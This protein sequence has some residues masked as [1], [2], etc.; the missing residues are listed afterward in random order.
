MAEQRSRQ[1][2]TAKTITGLRAYIPFSKWGVRMIG[3]LTEL[4]TKGPCVA[5]ALLL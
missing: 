4:R 3:S 5:K 2:R 1:P